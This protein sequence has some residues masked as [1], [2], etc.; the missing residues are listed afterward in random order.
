MTKP[1]TLRCPRHLGMILA[2]VAI[3]AL[4]G[5]VATEKARDGAGAPALAAGTACFAL[6]LGVVPQLRT[7]MI[8]DAE[9]LT[10]VSGYGRR[11]FAWTE[12]IEISADAHHGF[13]LLQVR[14]E[15]RE[16]QAAF[17]PVRLAAM[18]VDQGTRFREPSG[19]TP[20]GLYRLHAE[21]WE[22]WRRHASP[23]P[24]GHGDGADAAESS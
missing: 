10:L 11:R 5:V 16:R 19:D 23:L 13:W 20:Y 2:G 24:Q 8:L 7:R 18:P 22:G 9:G 14:S 17:F 12:I 21:L 6:A 1:R 4:F 3:A 15:E